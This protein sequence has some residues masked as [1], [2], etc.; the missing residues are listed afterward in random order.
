M[1]FSYAIEFT[2]LYIPERDS[3]WEDVFTNGSGSFLGEDALRLLGMASLRSANSIQRAVVEW[4]TPFRFGCAIVV[5]FCLWF[6]LAALLQKQT[7]IQ[8]LETYGRNGA[9]KFRA[10]ERIPGKARS[11]RCKSGI[12]PLSAEAMAAAGAGSAGSDAEWTADC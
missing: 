10:Q 4:M 7:Q 6:G 11:R 12:D 5:Y 1:L 3:G 8:Q 2:Q 9:R